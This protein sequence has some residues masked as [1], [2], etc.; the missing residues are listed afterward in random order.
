MCRRADQ[1]ADNSSDCR[2][3]KR[4]P[5][6]IA[7]MM[8]VVNDTVTRR[9]RGVMRTTPPPMMRRGNRRT[10]RQNHPSHENRECLEELVHITPTFPDFL[11]L[12]RDRISHRQNLTNTLQPTTLA[13]L[14][15]VECAKKKETP[16]SNERGVSFANNPQRIT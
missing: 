15:P 13:V 12:Q 14:T 7:A 6:G 9:R 3:A 5:S 1:P 10:G 11:S 4:D 8:D 16:R 2:R